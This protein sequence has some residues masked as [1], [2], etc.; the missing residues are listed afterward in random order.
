[1]ALGDVT[2]IG[3][4]AAV[5]TGDIALPGGNVALAG[6]DVG[7]ESDG[8]D[9]CDEAGPVDPPEGCCL[10]TE[11][12]CVTFD[13]EDAPFALPAGSSSW[14]LDSSVTGIFGGTS[15]GVV[16]KYIDPTTGHPVCVFIFGAAF[17]ECVLNGSVYDLR[18]TV[19]APTA[20][21]AIYIPETGCVQFYGQ[22]T[23]IE[24]GG[25]YSVTYPAPANCETPL[26]PLTVNIT[27]PAIPEIG[28]PARTFTW[29]FA[30]T[31]H[32]PSPPP[33]YGAGPTY[34]I[35]VGSDYSSVEGCCTVGPFDG[36]DVPNDPPGGGGDSV[37]TPCCPIG[38]V[39]RLLSIA[40][41]STGDGCGGCMDLLGGLSYVPGVNAWVGNFFVCG[42][43]LTVFFYCVPQFNEFGIDIR[44]GQVQI[45]TPSP[46]TGFCPPLGFV[47]A[48]GVN[49]PDG[50]GCCPGGGNLI[51]TVFDPS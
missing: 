42:Q 12:A 25:D 29:T 18:L 16:A 43:F 27:L 44:C 4:G 22:G 8:C 11:S 3:G 24:D 51:V 19:S 9:C 45:G 21:H 41:I 17:L 50:S 6:G 32:C 39:P 47:Q 7:E 34:G 36:G 30:V 26:T 37:G 10:E 23:R 35:A 5:V 38:N 14:L 2:T 31:P 33:G 13:I 1:M 48:F 28:M 20:V 40:I 46:A 49:I 15:V